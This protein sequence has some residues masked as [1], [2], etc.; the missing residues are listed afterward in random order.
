MKDLKIVVVRQAGESGQL[1]GSV[2]ARDLAK[3]IVDLG[4]GV[5]KRQIILNKPI[6]SLGLYPIEIVLHPEVK[7]AGMA[8]VAQSLE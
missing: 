4:F 1:Y 8:N 7:V 2:T 3:V 5:D 6:K